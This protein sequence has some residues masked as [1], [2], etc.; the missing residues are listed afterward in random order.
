MMSIPGY[1]PTNA[2]MS[3]APRAFACART[4]DS[5]CVFPAKFQTHVPAVPDLPGYSSWS[6]ATP[7]NPRSFAAP[8]KFVACGNTLFDHVES[9]N[10]SPK[11]AVPFE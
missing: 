7:A 6:N 2:V 3:C 4:A 8:A 5:V 9:S 10:Q 11:G 1:A